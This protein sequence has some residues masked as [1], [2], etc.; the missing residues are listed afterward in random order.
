MLTFFLTLSTIGVYGQSVVQYYVHLLT[1]AE[2]ASTGVQIGCTC[3]QSVQW[4]SGSTTMDGLPVNQ[5][6]TKQPI[7]KPT[8]TEIYDL[9]TITFGIAE[10][11]E[12]HTVV[13]IDL[14]MWIKEQNVTNVMDK[15]KIT[16][17]GE[18]LNVGNLNPYPPY[19]SSTSIIKEW[20]LN[21][22]TPAPPNA[23]SLTDEYKMMNGM[24]H[25]EKEIITKNDKSNANLI[26]TWNFTYSVNMKGRSCT[27]SYERK[28]TAATPQVVNVYKLWISKFR[29]KASKK[30]WKVVIGQDIEVGANASPDCTDFNWEM[31]D[32]RPT[33]LSSEKVWNLQGSGGNNVK[34]P[35]SD[36]TTTFDNVRVSNSD[37]GDKYG[38][39]KVF[40]KDNFGNGA[41]HTT[42]SRYTPT[43]SDL[44]MNP[45]ESAKVYFPRDVDLA[46]NPVYVVG[47]IPG[48]GNGTSNLNPPLWF[49]FW[50]EGNVVDLLNNV[51]YLNDNT[52]YGKTIGSQ[53][54]ITASAVDRADDNSH[55]VLALTP[56][57][58]PSTNSIYYGSTGNHACSL[59]G[60]LTHEN[61]HRAI[62]VSPSGG[63][64]NPRPGYESDGD[65]ILDS[66]EL[67]PPNSP[68]LGDPSFPISF[69]GNP[70]SYDL[71]H[72]VDKVYKNYGD[73]ELRCRILQKNITTNNSASG[74]N[75]YYHIDKDWSA[76]IHNLNW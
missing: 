50:K 21:T 66:E 61:Y 9:Y 22:R 38:C 47:S 64:G 45:P 30:D 65:G 75:A 42:V 13:V 8:Q 32:T 2:A 19:I 58:L 59:I 46:G 35:F 69:V 73:N 72:K 3:Y 60:T 20:V 49:I 37:F 57:G 39:V 10:L 18:L 48:T 25:I 63:D 29:D 52:V 68:P 41:W 24:S 6:T 56:S 40:C 17:V 71:E 31:P 1:K 54:L 51:N 33:L 74:W 44:V 26:D 70:D 55:F 43:G 67:T 7:V 23:V 34:I 15:K 12:R 28:I 4:R 11:K 5:R 14:R 36:L 27:Q 53:V 16:F 76:I 62:N